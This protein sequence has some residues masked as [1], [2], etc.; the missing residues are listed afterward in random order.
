MK[1][2]DIHMRNFRVDIVPI[3]DKW[4]VRIRDT[5]FGY[6]LPSTSRFISVDGCDIWAI[7]EYVLK[8]CLFD[9]H[10]KADEIADLLLGII[11]A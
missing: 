2:S 11:K 3:K 1:K 5:L 10:E 7:P 6:G 9:T 4:A 8:Y